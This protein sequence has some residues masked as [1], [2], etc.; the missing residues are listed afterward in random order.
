MHPAHVLPTEWSGVHHG[1]DTPHDTGDMPPADHRITKYSI[2]NTFAQT[3][4]GTAMCW[5]SHNT[6]QTTNDCSVCGEAPEAQ[7][8]TT[9]AI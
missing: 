8:L 4:I 2:I 6:A 3:F 9:E 1:R 7:R 5:C